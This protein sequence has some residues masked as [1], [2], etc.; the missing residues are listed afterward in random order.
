MLHFRC[1]NEGTLETHHI[2]AGGNQHV[3]LADELVGA[4]GI[5]DGLGIHTRLHAEGDTRREVGLDAAGNDV[6][7][8]T[9]RGD[10]QVDADSAGQLGQ[11][12][13]RLFH[14]AAGRHN[15][16]AKLIDNHHNVWHVAVP[17]RR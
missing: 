10:D 11:T 17:E 2:A 4:R 13:K 8:R 9:L 6:H 12:G 3:T 5:E 16:V 7:R 1:I 14:L 15:Q